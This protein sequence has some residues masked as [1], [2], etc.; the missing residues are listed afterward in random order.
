MGE[1]TPKRNLYKPAI[2][3][4]EWGDKVNQNWDILDAHTHERS[5]I[6]DFFNAP[7]WENIPDKPTEYP[8]S[9]HTHEI[10]D[11]IGL[12]D[13]LNLHDYWIDRIKKELLTMALKILMNQALLNAE[14]KDFYSI[15]ADV[16]TPEYPYGYKNT[17][18]ETPPFNYEITIDNTANSNDLTDYQIL[19]EINNDPQFFE[20]CEGNRVYLEFYDEDQQTLLNHYVELWDTVNYNAKIWIKVPLI[21]A[22][23]VKKIYLKINKSRTED[24]SNGEATFDFFD[25]FERTDYSEKWDLISGAEP[26]IEN[27]KLIFPNEDSTIRTKQSVTLA[28]NGLWRFKYRWKAVASSYT[29]AFQFKFIFK[30]EDNY[31][32]VN[33]D[34]V[35]KSGWN[36]LKKMVNGSISDLALLDFAS[37]TEEHLIEVIRKGDGTFIVKQDGT[38]YA[39]VQDNDITQSV[40]IVMQHIPN[41]NGEGLEI[42]N[43]IVRKYTDPEPTATYER[44]TVVGDYVTVTFDFSEGIDKLLITVDSDCEAVYYSTDDGATWNPINPNEETL[45]DETAY[46]VKFKFVNVSYMNGY[47]FIVW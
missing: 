15:I 41:T 12:A 13:K 42:D 44:Q 22:N 2:G 39:K 3:E 38:V 24:L 8:P 14:T 26:Y 27:G 43:I 25:D 40:A 19:L 34:A 18:E 21:P 28:Y 46:S 9:A 23:G 32:F 20:D 10:A 11:I 31:Y 1:Y 37:D 29:P 6:T 35:N 47:A 33:L 4:T 5:E 36:K 30:D 16:I 7:F 17:F 45:L